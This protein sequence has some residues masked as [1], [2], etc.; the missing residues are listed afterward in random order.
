[1]TESHQMETL[2]ADPGEEMKLRIETNAC[3][4]FHSPQALYIRGWETNE[5]GQISNAKRQTSEFQTSNHSRS[6]WETKLK[7]KTREYAPKKYSASGGGQVH[8]LLTTS[9]ELGSS[10]V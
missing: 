1:M 9:V 8:V 5:E 4:R 2:T 10:S 6:S 3:I 7:K